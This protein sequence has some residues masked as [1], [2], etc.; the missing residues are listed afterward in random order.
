MLTVGAEDDVSSVAV[1]FAD[2]QLLELGNFPYFPLTSL[3]SIRSKS[4]T[5]H[6]TI[7]L[8]I[9]SKMI[10]LNLSFV[11]LQNVTA[12]QLLVSL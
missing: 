9:V 11:H 7:K 4:Q 5:S 1:L 3:F 10:A 12:Q 8:V 2:L 6:L